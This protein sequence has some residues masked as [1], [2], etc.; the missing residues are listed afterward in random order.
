MPA[1]LSAALV[2]SGVR[3]D[4]IGSAPSVEE[5]MARI[6]ALA[7]PGD[8]VLL[9]V[10]KL[11]SIEPELRKAFAAHYRA[12]GDAGAVERSLQESMPERKG[13]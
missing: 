13:P 8:F 3:E 11:P 2:E 7:D 9:L 12:E 6:S 10:L 5:G 4:R 1:L